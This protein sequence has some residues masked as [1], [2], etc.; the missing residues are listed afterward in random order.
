MHSYDVCECGAPL[1]RMER[2]TPQPTGA[3]VALRLAMV[4][5]GLPP[6]LFVVRLQPVYFLQ[7][8]ANSRMVSRYD[9]YDLEDNLLLEDIDPT[10]LPHRA[11][12]RQTN[13]RSRPTPRPGRT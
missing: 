4:R 13:S 7:G 2:E 10:V 1:Q 9:V 11:I 12:E 3:E 5:L 8:T 6:D